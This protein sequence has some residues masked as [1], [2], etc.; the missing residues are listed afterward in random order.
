MLKLS[1]IERSSF[2]ICWHIG[3][4]PKCDLAKL[5]KREIGHASVSRQNV[6]TSHGAGVGIQIYRLE[7]KNGS[8]SV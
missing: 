3:T 1:L 5:S 7:A 2:I 4:M 6:T 8:S